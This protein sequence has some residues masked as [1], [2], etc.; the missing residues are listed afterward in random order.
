MEAGVDFGEYINPDEIAATL[1]GDYET[2][3][4]KAQKI[5]DDRREACVRDRRSFTFETVMSHPSK[6]ELLRA[7]SGAGFFVQMYFFATNDPLIN[8]SRVSNR[9][10]KGGHDVP[11]DKN[12]ERYRRTLDL[13]PQAIAI[14]DRPIVFDNSRTLIPAF[15]TRQTKSTFEIYH[16]WDLVSGKPTFPPWV[17]DLCTRLMVAFSATNRLG[18]KLTIGSKIHDR[19]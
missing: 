7:A 18:R 16:A 5:A 3:V 14:C 15:Y 2:R 8:V 4:R 9:V 1:E 12:I 11:T 17:H 19:D 6:L 13:A 10:S